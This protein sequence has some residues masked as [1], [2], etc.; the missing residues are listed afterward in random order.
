MTTYGLIGSKV[1]DYVNV[2]KI[3]NIIGRSLGLG[4]VGAAI[5]IARG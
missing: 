5:A 3:A 2:S 1:F 4:I